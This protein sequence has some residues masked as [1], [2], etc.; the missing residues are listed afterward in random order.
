M[1][2]SWCTHM[3]VCILISQRSEDNSMTI[4]CTELMRDYSSGPERQFPSVLCFAVDVSFLSSFTAPSAD[5]REILPHYR[6]C[7]QF[8][9]PCPKIRRALLQKKSGG[10]KRAKFGATSDNV[11]R[12][13]WISPKRSRYPKPKKTNVSTAILPAFGEK[14]SGEPWSTNNTV[15]HVDSDPQK[16]TF[17]K[18]H[19][20]APIGGLPAQIFTHASD[21]Q[22]FA[23]TH[24]T[25]DG[26]PQQFFN[27]KHSNIGLKFSARL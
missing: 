3:L 17:S 4:D 12:R 13:P 15:L 6:K 25:G 9:N 27:N 18:D 24:P 20:S 7:V 1:A 8:Y 19:I 22:K 26:V 23:T 14:K 21:W 2:H 10:Q 11:R 16:A 5:R